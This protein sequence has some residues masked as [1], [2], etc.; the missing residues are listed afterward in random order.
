[1]EPDYRVLKLSD[2]STQSKIFAQHDLIKNYEE[3]S[4]TS[5]DHTVIIH[6]FCNHI[7]SM[8]ALRSTNITTL[9]FSAKD[10]AGSEIDFSTCLFLLFVFNPSMT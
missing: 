9:E 6:Y 10:V 7:L 5:P 2:K 4:S 3:Q 1:L 8:C